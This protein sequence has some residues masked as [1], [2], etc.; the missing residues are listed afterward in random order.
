MSSLSST[1]SSIKFSSSLNSTIQPRPSS[2]SQ[3]DSG[4]PTFSA[5]P[6]P[7]ARTLQNQINNAPQSGPRPPGLDQ[8]ERSASREPQR[9][10][11]RETPR[12]ERPR[13]SEPKRNTAAA[14]QEAAR[15]PASTSQPAASG[16]DAGK[17]GAPAGS[18]AANASQAQ[19]G[20][21]TNT[22]ANTA[23]A[24]D[25]ASSD[26]AA[27]A[28]VAA[29]AAA[30]AAAA[31]AAAAQTG[32]PD[33]ATLAGLPA[34]F[35]ALNQAI[36]ETA[37][38]EG[39]DLLDGGSGQ[40]TLQT[41]GL[42][43]KTDARVLSDAGTGAGVEADAAGKTA[44]QARQ[45]LAAVFAERFG[46]AGGGAARDEAGVK[47]LSA[48]AGN[49]AQPHG[50]HVFNLLRP[51]AGTPQTAPQ[52]P[53]HT[54]AGAQAWAEDVGNQVRW[55]LGRAESKAELVL[56]PANLGKLEVSISLTGDQTTAQFVAS[57]QAARDALEQAM[58]RLREI[59][60]QAGI[61]LGEANVST[62]GD[63]PAQGDG[64]RSGGRGGGD[65]QLS[66]AGNESSPAQWLRR[67]DGMVD[68]FA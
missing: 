58:P 50:A 20:G 47:S 10:A 62:A 43:P 49:A 17:A 31:E 57:S 56:T 37:P 39:D 46:A 11:P 19:A 61:Q 13:E 54:A 8:R 7:F 22:A 30:A 60:Q 26:A 33:A 65:G 38:P 51:L 66:E 23:D 44:A 21:T 27:A 48:T 40:K 12:S 28:A 14:R 34:A 45:P 15:E 18:D 2:G 29:A 67:H 5:E 1:V 52:L 53:V 25:A 41:S 59:L 35:A 16:Q 55:M 4:R 42:L 6:E 24:T 9:E 36:A 3:I 68:T 63:Q 32:N 64:G